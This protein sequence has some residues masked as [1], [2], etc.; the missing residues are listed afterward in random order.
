[1]NTPQ[2][3]ARVRRCRF[4]APVKIKYARE[5]NGAAGL[6][7]PQAPSL[8]L[9]LPLSSLMAGVLEGM[10]DGQAISLSLKKRSMK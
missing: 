8:R 9:K 6:A 7:S 3:A 10:K 4:T 1:M 2:V 5:I